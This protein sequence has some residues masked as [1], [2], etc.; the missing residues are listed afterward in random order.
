MLFSDLVGCLES[1]S[2]PGDVIY[3]CY[4]YHTLPG[5]SFIGKSS[6]LKKGKSKIIKG[7]SSKIRLLENGNFS[8]VRTGVETALKLLLSMASEYMPRSH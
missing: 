8:V 1:L 6:A 4:L 7:C 3:I 2:H 5:Q